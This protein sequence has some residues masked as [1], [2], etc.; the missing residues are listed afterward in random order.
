VDQV[1]GKVQEVDEVVESG[2]DGW[3]IDWFGSGYLSE[4]EGM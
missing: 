4:H 1:W 2:E 3:H